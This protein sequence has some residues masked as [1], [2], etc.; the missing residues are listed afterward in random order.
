MKTKIYVSKG[1]AVVVEDEV[2]DELYDLYEVLNLH[3]AAWIREVD[4]GR[5]LVIF[6]TAS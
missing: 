3:N 4:E 6:P 2:T 1:V 5:K